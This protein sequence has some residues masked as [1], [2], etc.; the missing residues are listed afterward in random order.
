MIGAGLAGLAAAPAL[1]QTSGGAVPRYAVMSILGDKITLV[2]YQPPIGS[3]LDQNDKRVIPITSPMFDNSALLAVDDA[4]KR[5]QPGAVT[6]LLASRDP[7]LFALQ[8]NSLDQP[9]DAA[10]SV[11]AIK[12]LLLQSNATRLILLTPY[13]SEARFQMRENLVGSGHISGLAL[14]L[15]RIMRVTRTSTGEDGT[16]Y[17]APYA[18]FSVSL[19]DAATLK[20]VRRKLLTESEVVPTSASKAA[21][22]PWE[23]LT[24][25]QKVEALQRLIRRGVESAIPELLA[26]V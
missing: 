25:A 10:D 14:Y 18:Y 7:R 1:A 24:D 23:T 4:I 5:I 22:V 6:T 20:T 12:A 11:A 19:I 13:R 26:G 8:G 3:H 15:D 2:G 16:G 21:T 17:L 9:G